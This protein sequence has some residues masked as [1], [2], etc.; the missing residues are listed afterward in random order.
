[1]KDFVSNYWI[2]VAAL[3]AA[4]AVFYTILGPYG[5]PWTALAWVILVSSAVGLSVRAFLAVK[6]PRSITQ[7]LD[8]VDTEPVLAAVVTERVALP[9]G[10]VQLRLK[11]EETL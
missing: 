4:L 8:D 10:G 5:F 1:M 3:V 6:S 2:S 7:M 11:R 9:G